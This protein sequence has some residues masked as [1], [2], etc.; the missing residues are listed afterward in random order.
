MSVVTHFIGLLASIVGL[1]FMVIYAN[2]YGSVKHIIGFSIFG[3]SMILL[4]AASS[5]YH[6]F[7]KMSKIKAIFRRIDCS[8][9][10]VLIAGSYTPICLLMEN[11]VCG[12]GLLVTVWIITIVGI[13]LNIANIKIKEWIS[14][15]VYVL[16]GALLLIAFKPISSW[17]PENGLY[18]LYGGGSLYLIGLIFYG[19]ENFVPRKLFGMHEVWHLFVMAANFSHVGLMINYV[20]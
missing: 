8:M 4:Y 13:F 10:F 6:Y 9:V 15:S 16:I 12:L 5:L 7:P 17:L 11:Q 14:V 2:T 1:I 18:L 3:I 19:L 20:L